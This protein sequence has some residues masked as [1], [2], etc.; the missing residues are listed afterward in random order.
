[1]MNDINPDGSIGG[2]QSEKPQLRRLQ[3]VVQQI[4]FYPYHNKFLII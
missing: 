3:K 4:S 2:E 1:M